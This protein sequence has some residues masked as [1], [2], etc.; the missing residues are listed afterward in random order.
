MRIIIGLLV[1]FPINRGNNDLSPEASTKRRHL[2]LL[3]SPLKAQF[4]TLTALIRANVFSLIVNQSK[5][6]I[7]C[8]VYLQQPYFIIIT[9]NSIP[10][11]SK[12]RCLFSGSFNK[13]H[14]A[15]KQFSTISLSSSEAASLR[16]YT[17]SKGCWLNV[18]IDARTCNLQIKLLIE[19]PH[20]LIHPL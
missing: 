12:N 7:K 19:Y 15:L 20:R 8:I 13:E 6:L 1:T 14:M 11:D 5:Y 4:N 3:S 2:S 10:S 17:Y 16:L 18:F 9:I